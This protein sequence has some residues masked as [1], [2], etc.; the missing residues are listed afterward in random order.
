M[1]PELGVMPAGSSASSG[2][3]SPASAPEQEAVF[4]SGDPVRKRN[5]A[6]GEWGAGGEEAGRIGLVDL[7]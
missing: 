1:T 5:L 2:C 3:L 7:G 6:Q 4:L